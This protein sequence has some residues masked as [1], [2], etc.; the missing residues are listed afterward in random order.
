LSCTLAHAEEKLSKEKRADIQ[1]LMTL[2]GSA[3]IGKRISDAMI[4][5]LTQLL[6]SKEPK[7]TNKALQVMQKVV[8]ASVDEYMQGDEGFM[9]VFINLYHKHFTH[10]DIKGLIKFNETE[11]GK[12]SV[13]TMPLLARDS[14]DAEKNW[15]L[16]VIPVIEKRLSKELKKEGVDL[17]KK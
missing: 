13:Q 16:K 17:D 14:Y 10:E 2:T 15:S 7:I 8:R 6:K 4:V 12:K 3:G 9:N 5:R 1:K 11:L